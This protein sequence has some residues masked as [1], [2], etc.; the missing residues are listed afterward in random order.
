MSPLEAVRSFARVTAVGWAL[1]MAVACGGNSRAVVV[2]GSALGDGGAYARQQMLSV[3]GF[4][5]IDLTVEA[6]LPNHRVVLGDVEM[7]LSDAAVLADVIEVS[8]GK[9]YSQVDDSE[10]KG[11]RI[12]YESPHAMWRTAYMT[13]KV[14]EVL[15]GATIDIAEIISV[16]IGIRGGPIDSDRL[17][18]SLQDIGRAVYFVK[19]YEQPREHIDADYRLT[20]SG[21]ST[22]SVGDDGNLYLPLYTPAMEEVLRPGAAELTAERDMV[23]VGLTLDELRA[24]AARP[25]TVEAIDRY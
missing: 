9:A 14:D 13:L 24:M 18:A 6:L 25:I 15:G 11:D 17:T 7:A 10:D 23:A 20:K 3:D 1:V 19:R 21:A 4:S 16:R 12:P 2:E 8:T 22:M 5:L